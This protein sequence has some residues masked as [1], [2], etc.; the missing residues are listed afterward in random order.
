MWNAAKLG[1]LAWRVRCWWLSPSP[2]SEVILRELN[3]TS[4]QGYIPQLTASRAR[5][6]L[7]S[8]LCPHTAKVPPFRWHQSPFGLDS[9]PPL[10]AIVSERDFNCCNSSL[11]ETQH[12]YLVCLLSGG[13]RQDDRLTVMK[14][15]QPGFEWG[16]KAMH[17]KKNSDWC[18]TPSLALHSTQF[19]GVYQ[20]SVLF[21]DEG[22]LRRSHS[23]FGE[24]WYLHCSTA[25][26]FLIR[27]PSKANV[28]DWAKLTHLLTKEYRNSYLVLRK[29]LYVNVIDLAKV[30]GNAG[31]EKRFKQ[32]SM[33]TGDV[34]QTL[35]KGRVCFSTELNQRFGLCCIGYYWD[36]QS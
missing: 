1:T 4:Q 17:L 28:F 9:T 23:W 7:N 10:P 16:E 8:R 18:V 2:P 27:P 35:T 5:L 20:C 21:Q 29:M 26:F 13:Y 34:T 30:Q 19:L 24:V 25:L 32:L 14:M 12:S 33:R 22:G 15:C 3:K 31:F 36:I 11:T 6:F